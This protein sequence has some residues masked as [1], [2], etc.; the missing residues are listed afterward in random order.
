MAETTLAILGVLG[1]LGVLITIL[2]ASLI[3]NMLNA[4]L[5]QQLRQIGVMKLIGGRSAQI[6]PMYLGMIVAYS[7]MALIVAVPAGALA[8]YG[9]ALFI[10]NMMGAVVQGFRIVPLAIVA[11][12]LV[13]FLVPL[14]AGFFPVNSGAKTNV[15]RAISNY[16]PGNQLARQ[17]LFT[18]TQ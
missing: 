12:V 4:M 8:G 13:A 3:V 15:R 1:A 5:T 9:L 14:T 18:R 10:S 16:R 7:V 6:L 17:G 2:S 11:Q